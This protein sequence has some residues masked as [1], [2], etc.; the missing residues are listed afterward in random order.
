MSFL[1]FLHPWLRK[2]YIRVPLTSS[3]RRGA[4]IRRFS[5]MNLTVTGHLLAVIIARA[6]M[7][8]HPRTAQR[9]LWSSATLAESGRNDY[10]SGGPS[11]LAAYPGRQ[12]QSLYGNLLSYSGYTSKMK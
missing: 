4:G 11:F 5:K 8:K 6:S 10:Y 1:D 12:W 2:R 7:L 9:H 3:L